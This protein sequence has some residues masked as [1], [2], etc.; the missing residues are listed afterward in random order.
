MF[1]EEDAVDKVLAAL[2]HNIDGKEV[3]TKKAI[4]HAIHQV[5][6]NPSPP[7]CPR[8]L[9]LL[10]LFTHQQLKQRTKKIFVGGVPRDMPEE[11]IKQ[12]FIQ[13]GEVSS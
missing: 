5:R 10:S 2:P 4:P 12:Y 11:V 6:T 13:F 3:D 9:L 7:S 1:A 8:H